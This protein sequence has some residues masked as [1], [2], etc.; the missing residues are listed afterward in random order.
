MIKKLFDNR[1]LYYSLSL[2][3]WIILPLKVNKKHTSSVNTRVLSLTIKTAEAKV[4]I[5]LL[6]SASTN[7]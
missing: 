5:F 3:K 6:K 7:S 1:L 4:S 2:F